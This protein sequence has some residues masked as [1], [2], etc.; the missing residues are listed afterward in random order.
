L[1]FVDIKKKINLKEMALDL[2]N[3]FKNKTD[4]RPVAKIQKFRI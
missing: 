4:L 1:D 3:Y 2:E